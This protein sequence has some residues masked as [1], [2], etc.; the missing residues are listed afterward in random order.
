M[1]MDKEYVGKREM[2]MDLEGRR[3]KGGSKRRWIDSVNVDS[4]EKR[5]GTV[6]GGD[7]KPGCVD[8]TSQKH[9]PAIEVGKYATEEHT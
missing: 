2:R 8:A 7:A 9:R 4:R 5:V 3:R 6:V 1:R